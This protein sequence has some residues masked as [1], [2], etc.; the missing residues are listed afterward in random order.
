MGLIYIV[1]HNFF[2]LVLSIKSILL[3]K[4][5]NF[6]SSLDVLNAILSTDFWILS[7]DLEEENMLTTPWTMHGVK[8]LV[9]IYFNIKINS[10]F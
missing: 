4:L 7:K 8:A 6:A 1:G 5:L 3:V 9:D 2:F 10:S